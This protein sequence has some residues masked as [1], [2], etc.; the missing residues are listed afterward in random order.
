MPTF[1]TE[2][3]ADVIQEL[4]P[5]LEQHWAEIA[6]Y[7]DIPLDPDYDFYEKA[8]SVGLLV[9]YFIRADATNE[10]IGYAIFI[11]RKHPHYRVHSWAIN[12]IVWIHPDHRNFG[13]GAKLVEHWEAELASLGVHV[14]HV[15]A[16]TAHPVLGHLLTAK[17]YSKIEE[18]YE[19]R[20]Q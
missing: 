11:I 16:K 7:P 12:D 4:K 14:V 3:Y 20:I 10:I 2:K 1:S 6:V 15:N 17:A 8:N 18:G 9:G 13:T 19:K 5:L